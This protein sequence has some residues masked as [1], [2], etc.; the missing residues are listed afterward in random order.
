[1]DSQEPIVNK[2]LPSK[3]ST[4]PFWRT[5]LHEL[6]T[7]RSTTNLPSSCD[8]LIIGGGYTGITAAYH[9]LNS[10]EGKDSK[11]NVML[12][13]ARQGCSGATARNGT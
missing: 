7:H 13:E 3:E 10:Y 12:M 5:E 9:L 2:V 6:D 11:P 8:I 4:I 1:M